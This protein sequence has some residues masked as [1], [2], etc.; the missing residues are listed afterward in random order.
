[1]M[2]YQPQINL[3]TGELVGMEALIRWLHPEG[4]LSAS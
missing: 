1:M 2:Y 4:G 3:I